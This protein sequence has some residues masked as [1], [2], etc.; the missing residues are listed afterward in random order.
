MSIHLA[1]QAGSQSSKTPAPAHT[2]TAQQDACSH[3]YSQAGRL[4]TL[5]QPSKAPA[6]TSTAKQGACSY[7]YS[8]AR[9][10]LT[11]LQ[12]SRAPAHTATAKQDA[13]SYCYTQAAKPRAHIL[14]MFGQPG[15]AGFRS[16]RPQ[17]HNGFIP[18]A[19]ASLLQS[20]SGGL[21]GPEI[22]LHHLEHLGPLL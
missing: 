11:L 18:L 17:H 7:C 20:P 12:P 5:L 21:T 13:C 6:H 9:R 3:C 14:G 2:A 1:G 22:T 4:L 10:L 15:L 16:L 8:Q 19:T